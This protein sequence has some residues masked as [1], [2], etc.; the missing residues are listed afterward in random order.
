VKDKRI[1]ITASHIGI[2]TVVEQGHENY[3]PAVSKVKKLI[4]VAINDIQRAV[5]RLELLENME[6]KISK[7]FENEKK[8]RRNS[9][10]RSSSLLIIQDI[11]NPISH[12][13]Q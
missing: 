1:V 10:Q 8:L 12:E 3:S 11:Q 5:N 7:K 9:L 2:D 4:V 6:K 13:F